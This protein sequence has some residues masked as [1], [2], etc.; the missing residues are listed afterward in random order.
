MTKNWEKAQVKII[1]KKL[2]NDPVYRELGDGLKE[3]M[4]AREVMVVLRG[5]SDFG[6]VPLKA[7]DGLFE[8]I[9]RVMLPD[10]WGK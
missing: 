9:C 7:I 10:V 4:I 2:A 1:T 5:V 8:A 3:A 6:D